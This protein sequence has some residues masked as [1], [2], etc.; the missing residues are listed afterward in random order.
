[1]KQDPKQVAAILERYRPKG[2]KLDLGCGSKKMAGFVGLDRQDLPE[3]DIVQDLTDIPW[4]LPDECAEIAIASHIVEHI[5]PANEGFLKFMDEVWRVLVP[6][7]RFY[8]VAPYA[9]SAGF[10][11]DPTHVNGVTEN[12][13][14]YFDPLEAH[15]NGLFYAFYKPKP[16]KIVQNTWTLEGNLEVELQKR[17]ED[18]SY[19][20]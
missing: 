9:G 19:G 14:L 10:W 11:A 8:I 13:W 17:R 7:G 4:V 5:N 1:M 16:W 15:G 20:K 3:V 12:T 18:P 6:D 2:V